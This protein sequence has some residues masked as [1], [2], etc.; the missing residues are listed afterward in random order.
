MDD[1]KA[2][3]ATARAS[4]KQASRDHEYVKELLIQARKERTDLGIAELEAEIDRYFDRATISRITYPALK[5]NPPRKT[6]RH[7]RDA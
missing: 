1:L 5:D 3:V 4:Q 2:A 6:T 7:R